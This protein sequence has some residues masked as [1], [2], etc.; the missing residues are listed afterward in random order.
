MSMGGNRTHS[1]V[2]HVVG[3]AAKTRPFKV[4]SVTPYVPYYNTHITCRRRSVTG[5]RVSGTWK[6][7]IVLLV[8]LLLVSGTRYGKNIY[9][10]EKG[11]NIAVCEYDGSRQTLASCLTALSGRHVLLAACILVLCAGPIE[12][13]SGCPWGT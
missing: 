5:L 6:K 13:C 1:S 4:T 2:E 12:G 7:E 10:G 11:Q 3:V 9:R 8:A